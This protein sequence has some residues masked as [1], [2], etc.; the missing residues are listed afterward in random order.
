MS[1]SSYQES[2]PLS[3]SPPHRPS[4]AMSSSEAD[5]PPPQ[6]SSHPS[7]TPSDDSI[8]Y[9]E[10]SLF[11]DWTR[12]GPAP[13]LSSRSNRSSP[14]T[15]SSEQASPV[16]NLESPI[17]S[18]S[19]RAS[20]SRSESAPSVTDQASAPRSFQRAAS[21]SLA[22]N[23]SL[24]STPAASFARL[25]VS[26]GLSSTSRK[27]GGARRVIRE[28]VK[29]GTAE[30]AKQRKRPL[31][32]RE[33]ENA[34]ALPP[35]SNSSSASSRPLAEVVP[36]PQRS[37]SAQGRQ[38]LP[39]P[40]RAARLV[41]KTEPILETEDEYDGGR[42]RS[43]SSASGS[44]P[45]ATRPRRSASLSES[46]M[47]E[48]PLPQLHQFPRVGVSRGAR[49]VTL[50]EKLRQE[51]QI[52]YALREAE[53]AVEADRAAASEQQPPISSERQHTPSPTH[54]ATHSH[55]RPVY[56]HQRKDSDTLRSM[57][58][59]LVIASSP[60][61][62]EHSR[63]SPPNRY[64][65][66]SS[67]SSSNAAAVSLR[68]RRSPTAPEAPTTSE[69]IAPPGA[70]GNA[71]YKTWA[72]NDGRES[73]N[74]SDE[75]PNG[76][77]SI[78]KNN[79][80]S[81]PPP[82]VPLQQTKSAPS[83]ASGQSSQQQRQQQ[84]VPVPQVVTRNMVVN[85]RVYVR[86]DMIGKGG[87]S[88]VYR[89][90]NNVNEIF[91]I[92][93]VS[94][95]RTDAETMSGYMNEIALLKRLD[96]NSRI[97]RLIDSEVKAGPGGSKGLLML[98]MECGEIDLAR[99]LQ[100]QQKEPMDLIWISYYWKQM[101]QAVHIIHEEKIVHSDLKP[102]NF[103]L[104]KGQLKLI[105]FG[106]ANAIAN[107]TTN[108]QR[109]HQIGTVNYM[110]PEAIELPDG[111]RRL[112]VGRQSDIW[113]LGCILYQMV[114]GY[115]P[116]QHLSVYQKMKAIPD[117]S[118]VIDFPDYSIPTIPASKNGSPASPTRLE[119]LKT[120]VPSFVITTI[121]MCLTRNPKERATI[122]Q[123]LSLDWLTLREQPG[124][125]TVPPPP[126]PP[127]PPR[128]PTPPPPPPKLK[129]D[130]A[131]INPYFMAQLL[132]YGVK[133]G[134]EGRTLDLEAEALRLV[135]DLRAVN[136][137]ETPTT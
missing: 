80:P 79:G 30:E 92:K 50:E 114:Y 6:Y 120:P 5:P 8:S 118:H 32:A 60:T 73:D 59:N 136:P 54:V 101:L 103:V 43:S 64:Y 78:P 99:L 2:V 23:P 24:S 113:S 93:R 61:V 77:I 91:A 111:M 42:P 55:L 123:L 22:L 45:T 137:P 125:I 104:V 72:V 90:M 116:F 65:P 84:N 88:R 13:R 106:I 119:H 71:L 97:I 68:H 37:L 7:P 49:R 3:S 133:C 15:S 21:G 56:T 121:K 130:E 70:N 17:P 19:R 66:A 94:L 52:G 62:V 95:D 86:L 129:E 107:D 51:R 33:K 12:D 126:P 11:F 98:V 16:I 36:V 75:S 76:P 27:I 31:E 127:P 112:K 124:P 83:L 69:M 128:P 100:E 38:V 102:A 1:L 117:I 35:A 132:D 46:Q 29:D 81:M 58:T 26:T 47:D 40:S 135:G 87:S 67:I 110:S 53:E 122:P 57:G 134:L 115:P 74:F 10:P 9:E 39:V 41:K 105:D 109:D 18:S 48:G 131:I 20:L 34:D 44:V 4:S 28:E 25:P 85:K 96:G 63:N 108:I 89:V 82:P 14:P